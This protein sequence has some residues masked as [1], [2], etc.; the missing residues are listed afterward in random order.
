MA[1]LR[2]RRLALSMAAPR[3]WS[4]GGTKFPEMKGVTTYNLHHMRLGRANRIPFYWKGLRYLS[5]TKP[6]I[7]PLGKICALSARSN[8]Y[9]IIVIMDFR[10]KQPER[11]WSA[12]N[13]QWLSSPL[14]AL[15]P[16]RIVRCKVLDEIIENLVKG[17]VWNWAAKVQTTDETLSTSFFFSNII[18]LHAMGLA[19][20][21]VTISSQRVYLQLGAES[22]GA[23]PVKTT[24]RDIDQI[25][26]GKGCKESAIWRMQQGDTMNYARRRK[27]LV[28]TWH[29][30]SRG[31]SL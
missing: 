6:R 21:L 17:T 24:F 19:A 13:N 15:L 25:R 27:H 8:T 2:Y 14:L 16:S 22:A 10:N 26:S 3:Y 4:A 9:H 31:Y 28:S 1:V 11:R 7:N 20:K 23:I 29:T 5:E 18:K 12:E 30:T